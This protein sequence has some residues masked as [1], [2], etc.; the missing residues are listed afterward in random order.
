MQTLGAD[1]RAQAGPKKRR[2]HGA[3]WV[4]IPSPLNAIKWHRVILD[5]S[6]SADGSHHENLM[7]PERQVAGPDVDLS[8]QK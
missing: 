1:W 2:L 4:P 3:N 6:L 8:W 5:V 7:Y